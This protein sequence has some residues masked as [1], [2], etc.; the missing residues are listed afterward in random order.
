MLDDITKGFE[1]IMGL[2]KSEGFTNI[3][4]QPQSFGD[5]VE[6]RERVVEGAVVWANT[7]VNRTIEAQPEIEA[8]VAQ[9]ADHYDVIGRITGVEVD[10]GGQV[11]DAESLEKVLK[12]HG[13]S[14]KVLNDSPQTKVP[15]REFTATVA[16]LTARANRAADANPSLGDHTQ[17]LPAAA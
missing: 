2:R 17:R 5:I 7:A 13:Q 12:Q 3:E 11:G 1:N 15:E 16:E 14:A 9:L 4:V 8:G 10:K 6:F